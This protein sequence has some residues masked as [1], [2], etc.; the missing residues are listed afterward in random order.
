MGSLVTSVA[1][2]NGWIDSWDQATQLANYW[3]RDFNIPE[4]HPE[5]KLASRLASVQQRE[6]SGRKPRIPAGIRDGRHRLHHRQCRSRIGTESD[7]P[8]GHR[9]LEH[10]QQ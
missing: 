3:R 9:S 7:P 1:D 6:P 10:S 8:T 4:V 2:Q 5:G